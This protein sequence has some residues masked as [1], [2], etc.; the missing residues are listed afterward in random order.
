MC[1]PEWLDMRGGLDIV[2]KIQW[3]WTG[4]C[5]IVVLLLLLLAV[6]VV[7][8]GLV[9]YKMRKGGV[10]KQEPENFE[11]GNLGNTPS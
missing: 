9:L 2:D 3:M 6:V 11:L 8:T 10:K 1:V 4:F 5:V 7:R